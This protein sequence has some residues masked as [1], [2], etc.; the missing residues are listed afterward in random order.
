M[1]KHYL[2]LLLI[3][4]IFCLPSSTL[5]AEAGNG[6]IEGRLVNGTAGSR[7]S[8]ANREITLK[9]IQS[10]N[11][12]GVT[13]TKTDGEGWFVFPG[14]STEP[15][16]SYQV[17]LNYQA[18]KYDG[19]LLSFTGNGITKSIEVKVYDSTTSDEAIMVMTAHTIIYIEE[20]S[21]RVAEYALFVNTS[22]LAYVGAKE[23]AG[24]G[25][26]ETLAFTLPGNATDLQAAA[27]FIPG[28]IRS[29]EDG[30]VDTTPVLPGS[31]ELA[32]SYRV[33]DKSGRYTFSRKVNYQTINYDFMVQ[34]GTV[35][36]VQ[37]KLTPQEPLEISGTKFNHFSG[38][39]FSRGDVLVARVSTTGSG[40][41]AAITGVIIALVVLALGFSV[42]YLFRKRKLPSAKVEAEQPM[43]QDL[44][45]EL[46]RLDDD[47][48]DGNIGEDAYHRLRDEKKA[49][50]AALM[51]EQEESRGPR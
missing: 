23:I 12:I 6:T 3:A 9:T 41:G 33:S 34:G 15:G 4:F 42:I 2:W 38:G 5:A 49:Q 7:S 37:G 21:L 48:E 44:L 50:L 16:Y 51:Q 29:T 43:E 47:F 45:V 39:N 13:V 14:L 28:S 26:K 10:N 40:G 11:E 31:R 19:E 17:T 20:G 35:Q 1:I 36:I 46:A 18:A 8:L 30:F 25:A 22:D 24:G 27:G 32:Y